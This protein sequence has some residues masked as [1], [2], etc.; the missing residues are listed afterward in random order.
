M[1]LLLFISTIFLLF[2][3]ACQQTAQQAKTPEEVLMQY[4]K[5]IDNNQFE[6]A[7]KLSTAAGK[8]WLSELASIIE[9]EQPDSTLMNTQ[10]LSINCQE[11]GDILVCDCVLEDQ[12]EKYT[13][14][15]RLVKEEEQWLI[16]APEEE[17]II[18]NDII[19]ALPDSLLEEIMEEQIAE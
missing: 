5:Y 14:T 3:F 4:Q 8:E 1:R 11:E 15:Y 18:E 9:D 17:I 19:E 13:A 10:F 7:K 16:D 6:E 2:I 12:Y